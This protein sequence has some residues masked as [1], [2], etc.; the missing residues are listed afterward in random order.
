MNSQTRS[1]TFTPTPSEELE[2]LIFMDEYT[3]SNL[4]EL[5]LSNQE[6]M[7]ELEKLKNF[8]TWKEWKNKKK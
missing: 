8:D 2:D 5:I 7:K 4:K 3:R 6:I 1:A